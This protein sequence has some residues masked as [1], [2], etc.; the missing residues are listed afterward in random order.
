MAPRTRKGRRHGPPRPA[1]MSRGPGR[2][3]G[4]GMVQGGRRV[5]T[6][7]GL[8]YFRP[9]P[10][11]AVIVP[12]AVRPRRVPTMIDHG[13]AAPYLD[14]GDHRGAA[15]VVMRDLGPQILGYLTSVLRNDADAGEVFSQF[16]EDLWRGLPGLRGD[17]PLRVWAYRLAWHAAARPLRDP[18]RARGGVPGEA[19]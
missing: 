17:C 5:A 1:S 10:R 9:A 16:A 19:V 4:D 18:Y 6:W 13:R 11:A 3:A 15:E 8:R 2:P 14:A 7:E 12:L